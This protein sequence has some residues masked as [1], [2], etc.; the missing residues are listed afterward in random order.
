MKENSS[1]K[2]FIFINLLFFISLVFY[3]IISYGNQLSDFIEIVL[4]CLSIIFDLIGISLFIL[5]CWKDRG[6]T[7]VFPFLLLFFNRSKAEFYINSKFGI[8]H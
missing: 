5:Y 6:V 4:F 1:I 8:E 3:F 2:Y 7:F